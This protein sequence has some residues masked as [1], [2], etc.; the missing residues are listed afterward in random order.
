MSSPLTETQLSLIFYTWLYKNLSGGLSL[1]G[2]ELSLGSF[3]QFDLAASLS[4]C[5]PENSSL[6]LS[7]FDFLL[8]KR[9]NFIRSQLNLSRHFRSLIKPSSDSSFSD[10]IQSALSSAKVLDT[11]VIS[12]RYH[13]FDDLVLAVFP[14]A[15][16]CISS[17][18]EAVRDTYKVFHIDLSVSYEWDSFTSSHQKKINSDPFQL[19]SEVALS[20]TDYL[21][22]WAKD[23]RYF[24]PEP[25]DFL[26]HFLRMKFWTQNGKPIH[27]AVFL[28]EF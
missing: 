24:T 13:H 7:D 22:N 23:P 12:L 1:L 15:N 26:T 6:S 3:N 4:G 16:Y 5:I 8:Q 18:L 28:V 17:T 25:H 19:D 21:Q 2:T 20:L 10:S 9:D 11:P 14:G 27:K